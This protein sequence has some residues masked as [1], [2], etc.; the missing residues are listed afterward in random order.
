MRVALSTLLVGAFAMA[1][2]MTLAQTVILDPLP[3]PGVVLVPEE[4]VIVGPPTIEDAR[5][6]AMAHGI[7]V[8]EDIDRRWL[9]GNYEVEGRDAY[10][11]ELEIVIDS[12]TGAVLHIDD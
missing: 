12:E 11:E 7:V 2:T 4:Y 5:L 6:I 3:P 1:P 9:D 10:G 8:V